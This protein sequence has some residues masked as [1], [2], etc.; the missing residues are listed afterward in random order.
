MNV[1]LDTA[2]VPD[3]LRL[4]LPLYS[5][6]IFE[7]PLLRNGGKSLLVESNFFCSNALNH[8]FYPSYIRSLVLRKV[9]RTLRDIISIPSM[10]C[11]VLQRVLSV[12][13][14]LFSIAREYEL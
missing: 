3:E 14:E 13:R 4:Y 11:S 2:I 8:E 5:E 6:I 10:G 7:S 9:L 1:I 12:L